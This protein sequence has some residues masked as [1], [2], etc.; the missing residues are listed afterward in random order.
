MKNLI[1]GDVLTLKT[2]LGDAFENAR[3]GLDWNTGDNPVNLEFSILCLTGGRA[4]SGG[5]VLGPDNALL[6]Y[7]RQELPG[8]ALD[9]DVIFIKFHELPVTCT[10]MLNIVNI[11]DGTKFS[12]IK[13]ITTGVY[14]D[15]HTTLANFDITEGFND[16]NC[17]FLGEF[18][19]EQGTWQYQALGEMSSDTNGEIANIIRRFE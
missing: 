11:K 1:K 14:D 18:Y 15:E 5:K 4:G 8:L 12:D 19:K 17:I 9:G 7:N 6:Y 2:S 16:A 13:D 3:I 10:S